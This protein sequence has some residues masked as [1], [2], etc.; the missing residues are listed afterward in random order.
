MKISIQLLF[1]SLFLAGFALM[2]FADQPENDVAD[3][4]SSLDASDPFAERWRLRHQIKYEDP[5]IIPLRL[6]ARDRQQRL[7]DFQQALTQYLRIHHESYAQLERQVSSLRSQIRRLEEQEAVIEREI[8]LAER[9]GGASDVVRPLNE[10]Q[11]ELREVRD[12]MV[13]LSDET[14]EQ[15]QQLRRARREYAQLDDESQRLWAYEQEADFAFQDAMQRL[16]A[17]I[18]EKPQMRRFEQQRRWQAQRE[19]DNTPSKPAY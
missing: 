4:L 8:A 3:V 2:G 10:L 12:D 16:D 18:G 19:P 9:A 15:Q 11:R 17:A 14:F 5:D 6:E 7:L 1:V 13:R